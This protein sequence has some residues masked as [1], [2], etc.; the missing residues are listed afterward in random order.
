[1]LFT[2]WPI[3][4]IVGTRP[5]GILIVGTRPDKKCFIKLSFCVTELFDNSLFLDKFV[6]HK[7]NKLQSLHKTNKLQSLFD[8]LK[9]TN[10]SIIKQFTV[11]PTPV[12]IDILMLKNAIIIAMHRHI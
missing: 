9:Q 3:P 7:T 6:I 11:F 4:P 12:K 8:D 1:M 5:N 10:S 2:F